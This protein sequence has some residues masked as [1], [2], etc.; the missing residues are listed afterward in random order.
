M[1]A[2]R[3]WAALAFCGM[4]NAIGA[5]PLLGEPGVKKDEI[6][7]G[8]CLP[9]KSE[10]SK[11]AGEISAGVQAYFSYINDQGGIHGRKLRYTVHDDGYDSAKS[12]ECFNQL[13]Q[14]DIFAGVEFY[15]TVTASNHLRLA[16]KNKV[17]IIG[18]SAGTEPFYHPVQPQIF[19][20]RPS[21]AVATEALIDYIWE[22]LKLRKFAVIYTT[23]TL[24]FDGLD[25]IHNALLKH[26]L[27][28]LKFGFL[29]DMSN[30]QQS[31]QSARAA[32]PDVV[33]LLAGNAQRTRILK[34][35]QEMHWKPQF[36]TSQGRGPWIKDAGQGAEGVIAV[37]LGPDP[38]DRKLPTIALYHRLLAKHQ[39]QASAGTYGLEGFANAIL[40]VEGL[41]RAGPQPT[42]EKFI[43]AMETIHDLDLGLGPI[44]KAT[45]NKNRHWACD[46]VQ[47]F[48]VKNNRRVALPNP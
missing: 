37:D 34:E 45:F 12:F 17:P 15:G 2:R 44:C 35:C 19:Q 39:P 7:I 32:N 30:L 22:K 4:I 10:V 48:V 42:R 40:L 31:L 41:K 36:A 14:D 23:D 47:L 6:V 16:L 3:A 18:F 43:A 1:N 20:F 29:R 8:A 26:G 46:R 28:P 27:E 25:S 21:N 11:V 5:L 33:L 9:L 24:G 38:T 13:I